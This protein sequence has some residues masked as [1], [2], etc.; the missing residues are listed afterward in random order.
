[1][2]GGEAVQDDRSGGIRRGRVAFDEE[3]VL[4]TPGGDANDQCTDSG[5]AAKAMCGVGLDENEHPGLNFDDVIVEFQVSCPFEDVIQLGASLVVV[6]HRVGDEG[7]V[8]VG[9]GRVL[10]CEDPGALAAGTGDDRGLG[11]ASDDVTRPGTMR[12][13]DSGVHR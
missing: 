10:M 11:L 2:E 6:L 3:F 13:G 12:G 1:V 7:H 5:L 9:R 4:G 8:K